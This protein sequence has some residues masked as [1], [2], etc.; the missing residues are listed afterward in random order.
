MDFSSIKIDPTIPLPGLRT[1]Y[2][3]ISSM[4]SAAACWIFTIAVT[5]SRLETAGS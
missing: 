4:C 5:M 3:I 1:S 2:V